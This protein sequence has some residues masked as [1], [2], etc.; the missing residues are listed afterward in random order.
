MIKIETNLKQLR[1]V[2]EG[3]LNDLTGRGW[4]LVYVIQEEHGRVGTQSLMC[5]GGSGSE[6]CAHGRSEGQCYAHYSI[7]GV[8]G[9]T[10]TKYIVGRPEKG[11][12]AELGHELEDRES[13]VAR[14][15]DDSKRADVKH[16]E[17]FDEL[18]AMES[19][20]RKE[21]SNCDELRQENLDVRKDR[22]EIGKKIRLFEH[23]I[24]KLRNEFGDKVVR[25]VLE[26]DKAE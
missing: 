10:E 5:Q 9:D 14:L 8:V 11:A 12:L 24:A 3:G 19:R 26:R 17:T 23:D 25:E 6:Q 21:K 1:V 22:D 20:F 4:E 15:K 18:G 16:K 13:E 2:N 7:P